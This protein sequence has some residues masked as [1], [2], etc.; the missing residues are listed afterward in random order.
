[1]KNCYKL[2]HTSA[3]LRWKVSSKNPCLLS[4][5]SS[6]MV[7]VCLHLQCGMLSVQNSRTSLLVIVWRRC[8]STTSLLLLYQECW[9]EDCFT[10]KSAAPWINSHGN[11]SITATSFVDHTSRGF[12]ENKGN[13]T[14]H[15]AW[16]IKLYYRTED[17]ASGVMSVIL[18]FWRASRESTGQWSLSLGTGSSMISFLLLEVNSTLSF[19]FTNYHLLL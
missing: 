5:P 2:A 14:S 10:T 16:S 11:R 6:M 19:L 9:K 1:M 15:S 18:W 3:S 17:H 4:V 8:W 12:N 7:T 13:T